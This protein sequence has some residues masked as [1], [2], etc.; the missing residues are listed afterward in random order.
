MIFVS[1]PDK[2]DACCLHILI[3]GIFSLWFRITL[4]AQ[5][6][7]DLRLFPL[8]TQ[9][10]DLIIE[11]CKYTLFS[12]GERN[13]CK[14][15]KVWVR[16]QW[17]SSPALVSSFRSMKRLGISLLPLDGML[18]YRRVIPSIKFAGTHL[19]IWMKRGKCVSREQN[20]VTPAKAR[21]RTTRSRI[22]RLSIKPPRHQTYRCKIN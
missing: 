17:P 16:D 10:C 12:W 13:Y 2:L 1:F 3:I 4:T 6:D 11:S 14:E 8:D 9:N 15:L 22:Q 19:Y 18:V 5:C 21:T 20:V 7:M